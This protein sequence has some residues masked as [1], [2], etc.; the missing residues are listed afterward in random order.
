MTQRWGKEMQLMREYFGVIG[1]EEKQLLLNSAAYAFASRHCQG[2][3]EAEKLK[4]S[5][6][7]NT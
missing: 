5:T 7:D 2:E 3:A 1:A 4:R 6:G